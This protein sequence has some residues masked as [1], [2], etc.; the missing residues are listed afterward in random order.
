MIYLCIWEFKLKTEN[1]N[2]FPMNVFFSEWVWGNPED[3]GEHAGGGKK[4][5][6]RQWRSFRLFHALVKNSQ[7]PNILARAWRSLK[8]SFQLFQT[9]LEDIIVAVIALAKENIL[10]I[11][12]TA[13][14]EEP[15]FQPVYP[16]TSNLTKIYVKD[17]PKTA[18]QLSPNILVPSWI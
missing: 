3:Q 4:I 8:G 7:A 14:W 11:V 17:S 18:S 5:R 13:N 9:I 10:R 2:Y 15:V 12:K 6:E 1:K 16:E